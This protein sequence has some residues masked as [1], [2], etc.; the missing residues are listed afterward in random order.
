MNLL[1]CKLAH[2]LAEN[3][4]DSFYEDEIRY[5]LE[6]AL[7]ALFQLL[8]IALVALL[9]GIGKEVIAIAISAALYRR[10]SGGAHCQAYY[11]CTL[12]S[13]GNFILLGFISKYIPPLYWPSYMAVIAVLSI[14]VIH[15]YVPVDNPSCRITDEAI[16]EKRRKKTYMIVLFVMVACVLSRYIHEGELY[17]IALLL[18][19]LWQNFTLLP[20]GNRYICFLDQIFGK[21]E[22][23]LGR[24]VT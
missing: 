17:S 18:G 21:V 11:R 15:R 24:V 7:G 3:A 10:Y 1:A 14:V 16:R 9:L 4:N 5:G 13:L 23:I 12:T 22:E 20:L 6:I 2:L 8:I 19:L